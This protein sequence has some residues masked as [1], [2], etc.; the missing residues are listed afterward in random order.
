[1]VQ[2]NPDI[3][4]PLLVRKRDG[5]SVPVIVVSAMGHLLQGLRQSDVNAAGVAEVLAK[6]VSYTDL[7]AAISRVIGPP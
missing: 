6:P 1:M 5:R 2:P 7:I 4:A 3:T